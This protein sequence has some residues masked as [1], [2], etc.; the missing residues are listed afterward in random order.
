MVGHT[1]GEAIVLQ[2]DI[3]ELISQELLQGTN[4]AADL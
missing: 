1:S 3:Q 4:T 2:V